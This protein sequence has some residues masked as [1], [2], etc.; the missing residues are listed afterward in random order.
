ML[1]KPTKKRSRWP[2]VA[3]AL[4]LLTPVV[5]ALSTAPVWLLIEPDHFRHLHTYEAFYRPLSRLAAHNESFAT[6]MD[7]YEH[8]WV[9]DG[10]AF[11]G[12]HETYLNEHEQRAGPFSDP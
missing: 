10:R 3:M 12:W 11:Y 9:R 8:I 2:A 7:W 6:A 5:Y 4:V 1:E